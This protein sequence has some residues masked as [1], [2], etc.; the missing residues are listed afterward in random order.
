MAIEDAI[1]LARTLSLETDPERALAR[2][3]DARRPRSRQRSGQQI[4][5]GCGTATPMRTASVKG[6]APS[7]TMLFRGLSDGNIVPAG[8]LRQC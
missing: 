8:F 1:A 2:Y 4:R 5:D 3:Q 7:V 6:Q